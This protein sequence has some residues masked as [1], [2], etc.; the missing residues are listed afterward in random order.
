M[1]RRAQQAAQRVEAHQLMR[2]GLHNV[3]LCARCAA[4]VTIKLVNGDFAWRIASMHA[5]LTPVFC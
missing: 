3:V 4:A 1:H 2:D 5:M